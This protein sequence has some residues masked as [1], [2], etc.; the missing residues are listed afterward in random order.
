MGRGYCKRR[1]CANCPRPVKLRQISGVHRVRALTATKLH[2]C[3]WWRCVRLPHACLSRLDVFQTGGRY[4]PKWRVRNV[5]ARL[6]LQ[7]RGSW[8]RQKRCENRIFRAC[9]QRRQQSLTSALS[10]G[11]AAPAPPNDIISLNN[12]SARPQPTP[13]QHQP[14]S[15]R[16]ARQHNIQVSHFEWRRESGMIC[17]NSEPE[18]S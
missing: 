6:G 1:P 12:P 3:D 13:S 9:Q 4:F 14:R 5:Q 8:H 11:G 16:G 15:D 18:V 2:M 7:V 10:R 17:N